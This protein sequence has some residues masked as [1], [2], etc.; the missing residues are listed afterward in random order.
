MSLSASHETQGF[1]E[2][3]KNNGILSKLDRDSQNSIYQEQ[4]LEPTPAD[5]PQHSIYI[6]ELGTSWLIQLRA[7]RS[8]YH[9][10]LTCMMFSCAPHEGS[11]PQS[12]SRLAE[13]TSQLWLEVSNASGTGQA[14]TGPLRMCNGSPV[15]RQR[16]SL[17]SSRVCGSLCISQVL[18]Y[19]SL[20]VCLSC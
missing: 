10:T 16:R 11:R 5:G 3:T 1:R 2:K 9:M 18:G 19:L 13:G 6:P 12:S 14:Q 8:P 7:P 20:A 4:M 15:A 17:L